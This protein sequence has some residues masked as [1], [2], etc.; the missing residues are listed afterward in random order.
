MSELTAQQLANKRQNEKRKNKPRLGGMSL[1]EGEAAL[2]DEM[3]V[4]HGGKKAAIFKGLDALK[5]AT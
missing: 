1:S 2:L 3:A 5:Q 4:K